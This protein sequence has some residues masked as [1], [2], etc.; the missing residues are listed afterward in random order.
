M[1]DLCTSWSVC[2]LLL[3]YEYVLFHLSADISRVPLSLS[4]LMSVCVIECSHLSTSRH[5]SEWMHPC[6]DSL[7]VCL[8]Q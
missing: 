1:L 3:V 8:Y 2:L 5:I 7:Y 4:V 6:S